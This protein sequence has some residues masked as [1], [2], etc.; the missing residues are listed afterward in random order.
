MEKSIFTPEYEALSRVLLRRRKAAGI[1]QVALAEALETTQSAV[2]KLERGTLRL[3]IVQLRRV[4]S[5]LRIT[6]PEL[7]EEFENELLRPKAGKRS[8]RRAQRAD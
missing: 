2:S 8:G 1:T 3:D 6:L 5:A 7:V 4:C